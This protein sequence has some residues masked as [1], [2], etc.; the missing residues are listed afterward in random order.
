MD[1]AAV[2]RAYGEAMRS[3]QWFEWRLKILFSLHQLSRK[4]R[5]VNFSD[6]ELERLLSSGDESSAGQVFRG[7]VKELRTAGILPLPPVAVNSFD[8]TIKLRNF[9]AHRYLC[10]SAPWAVME[11]SNNSWWRNCIPIPRFSNRGFPFWIN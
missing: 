2:L 3:A 6:E 1:E 9:L 5:D 10:I 4:G 8:R 11:P 7:L